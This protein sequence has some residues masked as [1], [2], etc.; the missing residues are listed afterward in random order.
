[1]NRLVSLYTAKI[2]TN[3]PILDA[4][5]DLNFDKEN[6]LSDENL[7]IGDSTWGVIAEIESEHDTKPF[8]LA[9]RKFNL[10][11]IKMLKEFHF[12]DTLMKDLGIL[13]SEK[14]SSYAFNTV[15]GLAKRFPQLRMS[16]SERVLIV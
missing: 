15:L 8:F 2:L 11:T 16:D 3:S 12:G 1:M 5:D 4:G 13:Q 9:V 10:A 6:Q 14:T 7:G